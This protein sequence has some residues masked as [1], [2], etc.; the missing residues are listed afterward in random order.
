MDKS[1]VYCG[2]SCY[3]YIITLGKFCE[4]FMD[5]M[6]LLKEL[7]YFKVTE[8]ALMQSSF[9]HKHPTTVTK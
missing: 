7:R 9:S 4:V 8:R 3:Y 2:M 6:I 1:D 5:I